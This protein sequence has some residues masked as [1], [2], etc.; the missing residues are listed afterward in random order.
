MQGLLE[1]VVPLSKKFG[2]TIIEDR[3][4][5][6]SSNLHQAQKEALLAIIDWFSD[7][8]KTI[9]TS[10]VVMPTGSGKTGVI[11]C[12]PYMFGWAVEKRKIDFDLSKPTLVIAPGLTILNQLEEKLCFN[13]K[14]ESPF[15]IERKILLTEPDETVL[16]YRTEVIKSTK[17]IKK[18]NTTKS[19]SDV[20]LSN[21]QKWRNGANDVPNYAELRN[22]LFSAVIVDEAHHL[23]SEQWKRIIDHFKGHA[24]VIFFTATPMRHDGRS[25]TSDRDLLLQKDYTYYLSREDAIERR[26]IRRVT[27][28]P[29][30]RLDDTNVKLEL[31][32]VIK[33]KLE[34][35]DKLCPLPGG[36]K[37]AAIVIT[38]SK[39]EADEV[40]GICEEL[41]CFNPK[42]VYSGMKENRRALLDDIK[43]GKYDLIIVVAMLLEGFDHPPLSVA[44]IL[45]KIQ[46]RV[47]FAQFV[48]RIQRLVR[49]P[50]IEDDSI[51]G[52][53]IT[54][55]NYEQ[56]DLYYKYE[57][58]TIVDAEHLEN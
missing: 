17:S 24:K 34:E 47:K 16:H 33:S 3:V 49:H 31:L 12:L 56:D 35:K 22:D 15:L 37:H 4:L 40:Y 8:G 39:D 1:S 32:R 20:V 26:L 5:K 46:S 14:N 21:A 2:P 11:S 45:T 41:S 28:T 38:K 6:K 27:F 44:G 13:H 53:I 54:A 10:V 19:V 57:N 30:E 25:I 50:N 52:D 18:L 43:E 9:K 55:V 42:L 48:G 23:P 58:P 51:V 29:Y 7:P 36:I